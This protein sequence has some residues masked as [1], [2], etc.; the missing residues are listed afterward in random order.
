MKLVILA[1]GSGS[2]L[3]P[4]SRKNSPKQ[5]QAILGE[6][7]LLQKTYQRL[8]LE[9]K[10]DD[11][12]ISTGIDQSS[13]IQKQIPELAI[14]HLILE[15]LRRD[16][17]AAIG[18]SAITI[19]KNFPDEIMININSDHFIKDELKYLRAIR[20]VETVISKNSEYGVLIGVK[21]T[22]PETGY[23]YIKMGEET[24]DYGEFK[25]FNL[26][27][28]K[29]KPNL[30]MAKEYFSEWEYLWNIG[31]FAWKISTLL[32]LYSE[33]LPEMFERLSKIQKVIGNEDFNQTLL[34]E[35]SLISPI[36]MDYGIVEKTKKLFVIP[37]DFGWADVGH[38]KTVK[39]VLSSE[40][41]DNVTK[42]QV[43]AIDSENNLAY[44]YAG[45][46][47]ALVGVKDLLIVENGDTI[48]VCQKDKAQDVK[49]IIDLLKTENLEQFL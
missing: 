25:L 47:I 8:R 46:L 15:P 48:L 10:A 7:T 3:W 49:K 23:G 22:Y 9:F 39:D 13:D 16:T 1:G 11:I 28:F 5:L 18:L 29:E 43:I 44:S 4:L 41:K 31:C 40:E 32:N 19:A 33:Y 38:W 30:E 26:D 36:S 35:F 37:A 6:S 20:L 12:Y 42:G 21:P 17:A 34:K 2:R 14:D 27:S 24:D 45:K